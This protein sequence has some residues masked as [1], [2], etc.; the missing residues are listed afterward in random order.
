MLYIIHIYMGGC[1]TD[2]HSQRGLACRRTFIPFAPFSGNTRIEQIRPYHQP[3]H[4]YQSPPAL[5][6]IMKNSKSVMSDETPTRDRNCFFCNFF[7]FDCVFHVRDGNQNGNHNG[8]LAGEL[9]LEFSNLNL[10]HVKNIWTLIP[11]IYTEFRAESI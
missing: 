11:G 6:R 8:G 10:T 4:S 3:R 5:R 7:K 9:C 2:P 1:R